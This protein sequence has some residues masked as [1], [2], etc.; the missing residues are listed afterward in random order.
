M[1]LTKHKFRDGNLGKWLKWLLTTYDSWFQIWNYYDT[2][3][4]QNTLPSANVEQ[5][6]D[7]LKC[8]FFDNISKR[9]IFEIGNY[10]FEI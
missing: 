2:W 10:F 5:T 1:I 6:H 9:E 7:I 3:E 8:I 4:A